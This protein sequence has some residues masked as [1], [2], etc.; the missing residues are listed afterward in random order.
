MLSLSHSFL[1]VLINLLCFVA[2]N[3]HRGGV[4]FPRSML[5]SCHS[6]VIESASV[7][8]L[9]SLGSPGVGGF[10]S[11]TQDPKAFRGLRQQKPGVPRVS[12]FLHPE[13]LLDV[14]SV[15]GSILHMTPAL[16]TCVPPTIPTQARGVWIYSHVSSSPLPLSFPKCH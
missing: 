7:S 1:N 4:L 15:H 12:A 6:P 2:D 10:S 8:C 11:L 9:C 14:G 16:L 13:R 3:A 5:S